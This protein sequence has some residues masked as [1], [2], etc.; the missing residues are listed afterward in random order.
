MP[1]PSL[2]FRLSLAALS[3]TLVG[4]AA[5]QSIDTHGGRPA[6]TAIAPPAQEVQVH[7]EAG[8]LLDSP[9]PV[10]TGGYSIWHEGDTAIVARCL[11]G[12]TV[13]V[14]RNSIARMPLPDPQ[15][16]QDAALRQT[17]R[18]VDLTK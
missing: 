17:C 18:D 3:S 1:Q 4:I 16:R 8:G 14:S 13:I 7:G 5:A 10:R 15:A 12:G 6:A 11:E 2:P 9:H